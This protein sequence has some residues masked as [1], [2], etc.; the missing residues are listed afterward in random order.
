[1]VDTDFIGR[2]WAFPVTVAHNGSIAT[3]GGV[4]NIE[5]AI[6]AILLLSLIHI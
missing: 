6:R 3:I 4:A 1:M 5:K 2:G